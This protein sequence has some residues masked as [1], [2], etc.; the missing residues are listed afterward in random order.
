MRCEIGLGDGLTC[1]SYEYTLKTLVALPSYFQDAGYKEPVDVTNAPWNFCNNTSLPFFD[2]LD[3]PGNENAR[4]DFDKSMSLD[5][6]RQHWFE[7]TPA[8]EI[9][10]SAYDAESIL[11]VDVGGGNGENAYRLHTAYPNLV[12]QL[13]VQDLPKT[14]NE[15]TKR[16]YPAKIELMEYDFFTTQPIK[17]AK[18]YY[19]RILHD[20]PDDQ[21]IEILRNQQGALQK[22]YSKVVLSEK[23]I[24]DQGVSAEEAVTD[25]VV[26]LVAAKQRTEREW[27]HLVAQVGGLQVTD[28]IAFE[29]CAE[30][31]LVLELE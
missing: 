10:G 18:N 30:K 17:G 7:T 3:Q 31:I 26:M 14:I 20:W 24:P 5:C 8:S 21:A 22:G 11:M 13:V 9:L 16:G 19:L 4:R 28:V 1:A 15:A 25:F 6:V 23:V 12:G 29:G 27:R 2:W